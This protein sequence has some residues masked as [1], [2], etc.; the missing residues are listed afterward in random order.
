MTVKKITL[1]LVVIIV[2]FMSI[3]LWWLNKDMQRE[4]NSPLAFTGSEIIQL[5]PGQSLKSLSR[6]ITDK[7]WM[8]HPYY[9]E[10]EARK[11]NVASRLKAGEYTITPGTTPLQL[12]DIFVE[13]KV[14]QY[15]MTIPE[16]WTLTQI[17]DAIAANPELQQTLTTSRPEQVMSLAGFA[18]HFAEGRIFPDTYLFPAGTSD[19]E[20]IQRAVKTQK[21]V[22]Q[23]EW[24]RREEG[25]PYKSA[26]EAL[27]MAS[28]IEKETGRAEERQHIAG[29]FVRRL[30]LGMKL[31]TDPTVIYAMAERFDGNIRRK[32]LSIDS[33]Y[34]TYRYKGLP[35]TPIASP[36]RD[37]IHAALH[38]L[39]GKTLYFVARGDGSHYFSET[40]E[41][42]NKAVRKY[43]LNKK[44]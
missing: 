10:F 4:L 21:K 12:L 23:E 16:G 30:R 5:R 15:S 18:G 11:Q 34:N 36:G 1:S 42:H 29:V 2:L 24:A 39:P 19:I 14:K 33:P 28:I 27:I 17:L 26:Y 44:K 37:A 20:F 40:L 35:P 38:P 43:Q 32:D 41:E 8:K 9:L 6:E 31:Q 22:L 7:G 25:L 3:T 13:G